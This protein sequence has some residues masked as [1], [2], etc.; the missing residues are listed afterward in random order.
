[1][2]SGQRKKLKPDLVIIT[3]SGEVH[4][5]D[6]G[7]PYEQSTL[8]MNKLLRWKQKKYKG[9]L[10]SWRG[11][12]ETTFPAFFQNRN[13]GGTGM[14]TTA[15][16]EL[17]CGRTFGFIIG[18]TGTITEEGL[19]HFDKIGLNRSQVDT[20]LSWPVVGRLK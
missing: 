4:I 11:H 17:R 6:V 15:D 3:L 9:L 18:S 7:V 20:R 2:I 10:L 5:G 13:A 8:Y 14:G 19:H 16:S 1:M 12:F